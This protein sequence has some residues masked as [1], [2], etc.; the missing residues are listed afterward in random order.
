MAITSQEQAQVT[1]LTIAMFNAA[2]GAANLDYINSVYENLGKNLG[3]TAENLGNLE[4]FKDQFT[5]M[6]SSQA[7]NFMIS[8]F[9]LSTGTD[10]GDLAYNY[11]YEA[12]EAGAAKAQIL[13]NAVLFLQTEG[14]DSMF[15]E[16]V[17]TLE[18]KIEVSDFYS[19]TQAR[20]AATL[21]ELQDILSGITYDTATVS[22]KIEQLST[23]ST[24]G[25]S[26]ISI[27]DG[28]Y[29]YGGEINITVLFNETIYL[30]GTDASISLALGDAVRSASLYSSAGNSLT[31]KYIVEDGYFSEP[32]TVGI[33]GNSITLNDITLKDSLGFNADLTF[34]AVENVLAIIT[35]EKAPEYTI[36]NAHYDTDTNTLNIF[37]EDFGSL[38]E[39][40]EDSTTD[41]KEKLDFSKLIWD[42]D[43]D[44]VSPYTTSFTF[45]STNITSAKVLN[46]NNIAIVIT[47]ASLLESDL[48]YG[49]ASG[50]DSIDIYEGFMID[51]A[52]NIST[53]ASIDDV[54]LGIDSLIVADA[55]AN[56]LYGTSN[57]DIILAYD[58]ND[59][60]KGFEGNDSLY[61]GDGDDTINGGTGIDTLS[62][63]SGSDTF[64]FVYGD[65]KPLFSANFGIDIISDLVINGDSE[66]LIDFDVTIENINS[67]AAGEVNQATFIADIN[68]LLNDT[69][70]QDISASTLSVTD[71][72]LSGKRY[73]IVDYNANDSFD[74]E[75]F[76]IDI[77]GSSISNLT[78]ESFI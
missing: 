3:A 76:I 9:G 44:E 61:G 25:I 29:T 43:S 55:D 45:E 30:S 1:A 50:Q 14:I 57:S 60:L 7:A 35:D 17:S 48:S 33:L 46:D 37:G 47:D 6:D 27:P 78:V 56:I 24:L 51:T 2:P 66:D 34:E 75:D 49:S 15:D 41:I 11:M 31:F 16:A 26:S 19:I 4:L 70:T 52:E 10:A 21:S 54:I 38:L 12:L 23:S 39:Y 32:L 73:L 77:T 67:N 63:G 64:V 5:G 40:T 72:D 28:N 18:N 36:Y 59:T 65:S 8:T 53:T 74:T 42:F 22:R 20:S 69:Q 13:K 62:G 68:S 58:S 71:G